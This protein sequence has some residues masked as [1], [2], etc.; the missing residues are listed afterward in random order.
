MLVLLTF[1]LICVP[2][3]TKTTFHFHYAP[4]GS[5]IF[6]DKKKKNPNVNTFDF[7]AEFFITGGR[8]KSPTN[9]LS[10]KEDVSF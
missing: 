2:V 1:L 3:L 10:E 7:L 4:D 5:F 9:F 8:F 6:V